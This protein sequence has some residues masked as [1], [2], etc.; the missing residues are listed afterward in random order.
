MAEL[1]RDYE[2]REQREKEK[3]ER[4]ENGGRE[5]AAAACEARVKAE[6]E[7]AAKEGREPRCVLMTPEPEEEL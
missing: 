2:E 7:L 4:W 3:W 6:A 1:R 5:A